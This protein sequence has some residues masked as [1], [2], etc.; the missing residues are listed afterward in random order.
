METFTVFFSRPEMSVQEQQRGDIATTSN[1]SADLV[2]ALENKEFKWRTIDGV[3]K[4]LN[5]P[6]DEIRENLQ[7]LINEGIVIRSTVPA[8][9]GEDLFTTRKHYAE[10]ASPFDRFLAAFRNR[11]T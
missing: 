11:A 2:S 5:R 3:A 9:N 4:E 6:A 8:K 1:S 10:F 7:K